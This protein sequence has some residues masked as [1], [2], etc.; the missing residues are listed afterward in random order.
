MGYIYGDSTPFPEDVNYIDL[1]RYTV[2]CCVEL[3]LAEQQINLT[4][5]RT[6]EFNR[7]AAFDRQRLNAMLEVSRAALGHFVNG[8]SPRT[9][10]SAARIADSASNVIER[11]LLDLERAVE[12]ELVE[13]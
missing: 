11:E 9:V 1:V 7:Q 13:G 12:Q 10:Q 2:E 5:A 8:T 4:V 6:N 3:L